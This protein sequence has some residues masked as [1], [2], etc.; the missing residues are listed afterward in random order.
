MKL[1][2]FLNEV[3]RRADNDKVKINVADTRR[4]IAV[5]FDLLKDLKPDEAFDLIAKGLAQAAKRN[6]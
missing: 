1:N 6:R 5:M 2:D 4:V 3:A